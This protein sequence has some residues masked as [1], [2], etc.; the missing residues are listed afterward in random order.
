MKKLSIC[1]VVLL[2]SVMTITAQTADEIIAKYFETIGGKDKVAQI[3]SIKM[4]GKVNTQ[5]MDLP[6]TMTQKA[7]GKQR[8][9]FSLQGKEIT[10]MAFDGETGWGTNFMT[11]KAEKWEAEDSDMTK[12]EVDFPDPFLG[13]QE[14]GYEVILDGEETVDGAACHKLKMT[15]KPVK[16]DGE[17]V[18][19]IVYFF[20]DKETNV[21]I[22]SRSIGKKGQMKGMAIESFVSDYQ[23]VNGVYFP[24]TITQKFNGQVGATIKIEKMEVNPDIPD[25]TF[26]FPEGK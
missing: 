22:M 25:A 2:A 16:A 5:G 13:Y 10:Q 26:A 15:K 6:V 1:L 17:M 11:M 19:N 20:V 9:D 18:D 14:K 24:F 12:Q 21:V 3:N 8:I 4:L 7:P 23:E